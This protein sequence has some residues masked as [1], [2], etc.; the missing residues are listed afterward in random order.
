MIWLIRG[1]LDVIRRFFVVS[2]CVTAM[3]TSSALAQLGPIEEFIEAPFM[4][5][6]PV[7]DGI[8][9]DGEYARTYEYS[10]VDLEN[11]GNPFPGLNQMCGAAG[12]TCNDEDPVDG[13]GDLFALVSY[14]H[15]DDNLY[16]GVDVIDNFIDIDEAQTPFNNDGIELVIDGD[17]DAADDRNWSLEGWKIN[18]DL[19]NPFDV[20]P[21]TREGSDGGALVFD[22]AG[23]QGTYFY[24][25][26]IRGDGAGWTI[27]FSIPLESIDVVDGPDFG[28]A[29]TGDLLRTNFAINDVDIEGGNQG[30]ATHA[31]QWLVESDPRSPWQGAETV[32]VVGLALTPEDVVDVPGDANG[33]GRVN[34]ADLNILGGNWQMEVTGGIADGDFNEDGF[35]NATDLNILGGNWQFGVAEALN[36]SV[37]EPASQM[38]LLV[39]CFA[40]LLIRRRRT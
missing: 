39:G 17:A 10:F 16:I 21:T 19:I 28:S 5:N 34:A 3:W 7:P 8:V 40:A 2:L 27:E 36:A 11:P 6:P 18:T 26:T 30:A 13:D 1:G 9:N 37:P 35:V 33:D 31:M 32:W 24:F 38:V 14:A 12:V 29:Q 23:G 15:D 25:P 22:P 20:D 4:S